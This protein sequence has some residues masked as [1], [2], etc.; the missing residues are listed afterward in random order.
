VFLV[1]SLLFSLLLLHFAIVVNAG[2]VVPG[3]VV[4]TASKVL[5]RFKRILKSV[6]LSLKWM[7]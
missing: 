5:F 2:T 7:G 3:L 1:V 6:V 4:V